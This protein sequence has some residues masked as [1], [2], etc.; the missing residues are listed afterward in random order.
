M[1]RYLCLFVLL[2]TLFPLRNR[3]F[4]G[5]VFLN[6]PTRWPKLMLS[7]DGRNYVEAAREIKELV[8]SMMSTLIE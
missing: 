1:K 7:D 3:N 5:Y 2:Q 4:P 8:E 6:V